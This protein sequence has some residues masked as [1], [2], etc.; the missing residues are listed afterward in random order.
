MHPSN[1]L[2]P[3][4]HMRNLRVLYISK[5][6]WWS[7]GKMEYFNDHTNTWEWRIGTCWNGDINDPNSKGFPNSFNR[8]TWQFEPVPLGLLIEAWVNGLASI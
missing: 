2:S 6:T 7:V 1:R 4:S 3:Q 8:G 5:D